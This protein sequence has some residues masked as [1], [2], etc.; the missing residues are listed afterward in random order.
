MPSSIASL[1]VVARLRALLPEA[2]VDE[3]IA[4]VPLFAADAESALTNGERWIEA[5]AAEQGALPEIEPELDWLLPVWASGSFLPRLLVRRPWLFDTF[6]ASPYGTAHKPI[7]VFL[8]ELLTRTAP[9]EDPAHLL[10][11]LRHY[12][13]EQVFH[14]GARDLAGRISLRDV[15]YELSSL[16]AA[17]CEAACRFYRRRLAEEFGDPVDAAGKPVGFVVLAMGKFG[18][19]ELNFSS[20]IDP[21]FLFGEEGETPGGSAGSVTHGEFF[22]KLG[23][24]IAAALNDVTDEGFVFRVDLRLRPEGNQG[25]LVNTTAA[26]EQ[27]Y[28]TFGQTWERAALLKARPVAGDLALG[29][30]FLDNLAPFVYRRFLDYST[31]ED[32]KLMKQK[33]DVNLARTVRGAWDVKLG[34]G[35]IRE[36]EFIVQTQQLIHAGKQKALRTRSTVEGLRRLEELS[37]IDPVDA[38][39]LSEAYD[40]LRR[41]EHRL[42]IEGERQTQRFADDAA[43]H[44]R[45]A[46]LMGHRHADPTAAIGAFDAELERHREAIGGIFRRIFTAAGEEIQQGV[47]PTILAVTEGEG[48]EEARL[49]ALAELG[50]AQPAASLE[51]MR[52]LVT[53][54]QTRRL[55]GKVRRYLDLVLPAFLSECAS[56]PDPDLALHHL[57]DFMLRVGGFRAYHSLLAE[58]PATLRLLVRLFGTSTFLSR[59]FIRHPEL[60]D[61][62]VLASYTTPLKDGKTLALELDTLL[63]EVD[64]AD[65]EGLL[66]VLRRFKN[67]EVLRIAMNDLDGQLDLIEVTTQLGDL[68]DVVLRAALRIAQTLLEHRYGAAPEG[69][70]VTLGMGKFGGLEMNYS[71]DLDLIFI[72]QDAGTAAQPGDRSLGANEY[73][74]K[75]AQRVISVLTLATREG[76]AYP[77]DTR[78]RPSGKAGPLVT[79]LES[80]ESYHATRAAVWERQ[81]LIKARPVTA[82]EQVDQRIRDLIEHSVYE[83][84]FGRAE[85]QEILRMRQRMEVEIDPES[86]RYFNIKTGRGGIVDIEFFV[87]LMQLQHGGEYHSLRTQNTFVALSELVELNLITPGDYGVLREGFLFLRRLENRM[88]ILQDNARSTLSR[89]PEEAEKLALSMGFARGASRGDAGVALLREYEAV[90]DRVREVF[91]KYF[92]LLG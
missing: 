18:G 78:L 40:Y 13:Y 47:N 1:P 8:E 42:Q 38:Q 63:A 51:V 2:R 41:V 69:E 91:L 12:K 54:T 92:E 30:D 56:A 14:I 25:P 71:S 58:N 53:S 68:A 62:L 73:F 48:D 35:G 81:A 31:V 90:R 85:V 15:T 55:D 76:I 33:I 21:I 75:L 19:W 89:T 45:M 20:D 84:P 74:S 34:K 43:S 29:Q 26:A 83:R 60:L 46:R 11:A 32:I 66:D 72:Y 22:T 44:L 57:E 6:R 28:M 27:Y 4:K 5:Y 36:I 59:F 39:A 82:G 9:F 3:L 87:Q 86:P 17:S 65:E 10:A 80:F 49:T 70:F 37:L 16:A 88:R 50:F 64:P 24:R 77:I 67:T 23:S 7:D 52:R 79:S 61:Q